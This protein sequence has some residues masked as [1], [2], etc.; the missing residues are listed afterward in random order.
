VGNGHGRP[1]RRHFRREEPLRERGVR[2]RERGGGESG[3][4]LQL[5][6]KKQNFGSSKLILHTLGV[7]QKPYLAHVTDC[8]IALQLG[9]FEKAIPLDTDYWGETLPRL[10]DM[11]V[12]G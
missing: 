12:C 10:V 11:V 7:C 6:V 8:T 4:S 2:E 1:R 9:R 3:H 5:L